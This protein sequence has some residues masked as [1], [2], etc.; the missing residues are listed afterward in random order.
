VTP[1]PRAIGINKILAALNSVKIKG[2]L[3]IVTSIKISQLALKH[4]QNKKST[5]KNDIIYW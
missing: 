5:T 2:K 1:T 3:D 4:R